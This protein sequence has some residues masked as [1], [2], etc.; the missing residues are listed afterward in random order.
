M[1]FLAI[2]RQW[3]RCRRKRMRAA[4]PLTDFAKATTFRELLQLLDVKGGV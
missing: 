4:T 2:R 3:G 1:S